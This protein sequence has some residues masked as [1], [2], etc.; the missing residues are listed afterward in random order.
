MPPELQVFLEWL[1]KDEKSQ[2]PFLAQRCGDEPDLRRKVDS[3][4]NAHRQNLRTGSFDPSPIQPDAPLI[5]RKIGNYQ[6]LESLGHGA[7]GNVF[8]VHHCDSSKDLFALKILRACNLTPNGIAR[9]RFEIDALSSISHPSIAGFVDSGLA[10]DGSP[11]LVMEFV[12]GTSLAELDTSGVKLEQKLDWISQIADG[13]ATAHRN[14]LIHRDLKPQNILICRESN[15]AVVT[16]FSVATHQDFRDSQTRLTATGQIVGTPGYIAPEMLQLTGR[17]TNRVDIFGIGAIFHFLLAGRPP[18]APTETYNFA[19]LFDRGDLTKIECTE[20]LPQDL[21]RVCLK[22]LR[23]R[24]EDRYQS[25]EQFVDDLTRFRHGESV[26]ADDI[27]LGDRLRSILRRKPALSFLV[28][29]SIALLAFSIIVPSI[30]LLRSKRQSAL[31]QNQAARLDRHTREYRET[32]S[33]L[34]DE[35]NAIWY[36]PKQLRSKQ[37]LLKRVVKMYDSLLKDDPKNE[38]LYDSAV[39]LFDLGRTTQDLFGQG[40]SRPIFAMA[41]KRFE[42]CLARFP[43][44]ATKIEFDLFHCDRRLSKHESAF[45]RIQRV[46]QRH[47]DEVDYRGAYGDQMLSV[48]SQRRKQGRLQESVSLCREAKSI[49]LQLC[50]DLGRDSGF[51]RHVA[52]ADFNLATVLVLTTEIDLARNAVE[53]AVASQR[54][55]LTEHNNVA[56]FGV[57]ASCFHR[58]AANIAFAQNEP[59]D[60][61]A[62][63]D[64]AVKLCD[65]LRDTFVDSIIAKREYRSAYD[66]AMRMALLSNRQDDAIRFRD[67]LLED[68]K[69]DP[70][71]ALSILSAID[72]IHPLFSD[73]Y[74][75]KPPGI[76][77]MEVGG[78]FSHGKF[79]EI[80]RL[81]GDSGFES[82]LKNDFF[83]LSKAI[84]AGQDTEAVFTAI[85]SRE[86]TAGNSFIYCRLHSQTI[87]RLFDQACRHRPML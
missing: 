76:E 67:A 74:D 49:F 23:I 31:L 28:L 87:R 46:Y 25:I 42:T 61:W 41:A 18:F 17:S 58:L 84:L 60:A 39:A 26:R 72:A 38:F 82:P 8:L 55:F 10:D 80:F 43:K 75:P 29:C 32:I 54:E 73:S 47:P 19:E 27:S 63:I 36:D 34:T 78:L 57:E 56:T 86:Y 20:R 2:G 53:R 81:A 83:N 30:L 40:E 45:K 70:D 79:E 71:G 24:P 37:R 64:E 33:V 77:K 68:A 9:F 69:T 48:A 62:H 52:R 22:C 4:I 66:V 3:L 15:Q 59:S 7:H 21:I 14:Q 11:W 16:D 12:D 51:L 1:S 13:V 65:E 85:E 44:D 35:V 6:V 50:D 5:G